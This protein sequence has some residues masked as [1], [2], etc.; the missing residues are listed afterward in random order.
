MV[1]ILVLLVTECLIFEIT[2]FTQIC[3]QG[4]VQ[5]KWHDVVGD[6]R[7][8]QVQIHCVAEADSACGNSD[9]LAVDHA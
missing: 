4:L 5:D 6:S 8:Q 7:R 9:I 2:Q 1:L 3:H